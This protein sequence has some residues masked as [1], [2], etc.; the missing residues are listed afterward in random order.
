MMLFYIPIK[1]MMQVPLRE[2]SNADIARQ[3][4][5][6]HPGYFIHFEFKFFLI[7]YK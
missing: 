2:I 1:A 5:E 3:I 4:M 7:H 6:S